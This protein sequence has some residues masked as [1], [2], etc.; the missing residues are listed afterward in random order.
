MAYPSKLWKEQ[1]WN[2]QNRSL[3]AGTQTPSGNSVCI[4]GLC[5]CFCYPLSSAP[6]AALSPNCC[7]GISGT[8][9][10]SEPLRVYDSMIPS[11]FTELCVS[12]C[13]IHFGICLSSQKETLY[14]LAITLLPTSPSPPST[15]KLQIYLWS[16]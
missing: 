4:S 2:M 9:H 3:E 14:L 16:Q 13:I 11:V 1:G 15:K 5:F 8:W 7:I 6:S 12:I 10:E